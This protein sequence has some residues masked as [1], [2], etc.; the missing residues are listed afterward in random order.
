MGKNNKDNQTSAFKLK[1]KSKPTIEKLVMDLDNSRSSHTK[2]MNKIKR[3]R[4]H[5]FIE[6]DVK[7]SEFN[8]FNERVNYSVMQPKL[9]LK[10]AEWRI[11]ELVEPFVSNVDLFR[12]Y[13]RTFEDRECANY[14]QIVLNHQFSNEINKITL[15]DEMARSLT[16]DGTLI[17]KVGW[18]Y[19]E[20]EKDIEKPIFEFKKPDNDIDFDKIT[21]MIE[22]AQKDPQNFFEGLAPELQK[23]VE[24]FNETGEI[25]LGVFTGKYK[26]ETI[27][28]VVSNK[29][30]VT[31]CDLNNV[32][33]DPSCDG[34]ISNAEFVIHTVETSLSELKKAGI[35]KNLDKI[36]INSVSTTST[37]DYYSRINMESYNFND[38][39]RKRFVMYE[40]WGYWDI[41]DTG[42]TRPIVVAWVG[43]TIIRM[44]E[45][46]YPDKKIPF[47]SCAYIPENRTIYGSPD[48]E[49]LIDN[50]KTYS[51]ILRG[52]IDVTAKSNN[53]QRIY[54]ADAIPQY[55]LNKFINGEDIAIRTQGRPMSALVHMFEYKDVSPAIFNFLNQIILDCESLTGIKAYGQGVTGTS[56][57]STATAVRG[58]LT[59]AEIRK[60]QILRRTENLF[61]DIGKKISA[62]NSEYLTDEQ[63]FRITNNQ[64]FIQINRKDLAGNFDITLSIASAEEDANNTQ[65]LSFLLQTLGSVLPPETTKIIMSQIAKVGRMPDLEYEIKNQEPPQPDPIQQQMAQLEVEKLQAEIDKIRSETQENIA[66]AELKNSKKDMENLNFVEQEKGITHQREIDKEYNKGI[67][68]QQSNNKIN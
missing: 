48:A 39:A 2:Q 37:S 18:D 23:T 46:P 11:S 36:D 19:R 41:N 3:W 53:A 58:A 68:K 17:V 38:D 5:T 25:K 51:S 14:N 16:F 29:P 50:Q 28:E 62:L 6:G 4:N 42:V 32:I 22:L 7:L 49:L 64:E 31:V 27:T 61:K 59:A 1:W 67:I 8:E 52:I 45:N 56:L 54:D 12:I 24:I 26:T 20:E 13:P 15:C 60:I 33:V 35:Y 44:E 9:I 43:D 40:Y 21:Q 34:D 47:L 63:V 57:G 10:F 55:Q 65:Q 66:D 30:T